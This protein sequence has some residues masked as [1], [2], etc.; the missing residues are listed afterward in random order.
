MPSRSENSLVTEA[1]QKTFEA[2][3][4]SRDF[5][6]VDFWAPWCGPCR[7]FAPVFQDVAE[8]VSQV[9][10]GKVSFLKVNVDDEGALAET[11]GITMIPTIIAF[12][13]KAEAQRYSGSRT[14]EDFS[15]W[16]EGLLSGGAR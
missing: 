4:T 14:P 8:K 13:G 15:R 6:I 2:Q 5:A 10:P 1:T 16:I 3:V 11:Y 12:S 7:R 9:H